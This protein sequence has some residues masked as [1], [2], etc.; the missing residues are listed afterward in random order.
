MIGRGTL[1]C[2]TNSLETTVG[3]DRRRPGPVRRAEQGPELVVLRA[4][5]GI[6]SPNL[7]T[8]L[9]FP[10]SRRSR[11]RRC[12]RRGEGVVELT[13]DVALEA[14]GCRAWT[15]PRHSVV[16]RRPWPR[17]QQRIRVIAMVSN[18]LFS[19]RSPPRL[20]RC[21]TVRPLL[22]SSGLTPAREANAGSVRQRPTWEKLTMTCA[23]V[24]GPIPGGRS[25]RTPC[26][27]QSVAAAGPACPSAPGHLTL[28]VE[29]SPPLSGAPPGTFS[30][31]KAHQE[32]DG[33]LPDRG[34]QRCR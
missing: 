25:A 2:R 1:G 9:C 11:S 5:K 17:G 23:A 27:R 29:R 32:R 22:A 4:P 33:G 8:L 26:R 20:S 18:A 31:E 14:G 28:A 21:R 15:C 16:R 19:P 30:S 34:A 3:R 13:S 12:H 10:S 6:R 7:L 24:T